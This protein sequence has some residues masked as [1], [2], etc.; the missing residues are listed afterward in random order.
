MD[1]IEPAFGRFR[2]RAFQR[3]KARRAKTLR[4]KGTACGW[5]QVHI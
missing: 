1:E 2:E 4:I 3:K 5:G